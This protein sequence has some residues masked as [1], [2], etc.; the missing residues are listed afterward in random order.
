MYLGL[1]SLPIIKFERKNVEK[2]G[3]SRAGINGNAANTLR[4]KNP[5][6][7]EPL[8]TVSQNP[9][10]CILKVHA[11]TVGS[12]TRACSD[13]VAFFW[14]STKSLQRGTSGDAGTHHKRH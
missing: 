1:T 9:Q 6:H 7:E 3:L 14:H 11:F 10:Q 4:F 8:H 2:T 12:L 13:F 5:Y